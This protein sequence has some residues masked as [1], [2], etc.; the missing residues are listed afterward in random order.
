MHKG[1]RK[2]IL[3]W[4]KV[5]LWTPGSLWTHVGS[6]CPHSSWVFP[7]RLSVTCDDTNV[8]Q[9]ASAADGDQHPCSVPA[10]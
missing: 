3:T 9:A 7:G 6:S 8:P 10:S 4:M 1:M 5:S 2:E